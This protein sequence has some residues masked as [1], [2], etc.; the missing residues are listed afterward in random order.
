MTRNLG[1]A[2]AADLFGTQLGNDELATLELDLYAELASVRP[3]DD[4]LRVLESLK[5][6]GLKSKRTPNSPC[7]TQAGAH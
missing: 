5:R 6:A 2:G 7:A 1:L 3:Y 4:A